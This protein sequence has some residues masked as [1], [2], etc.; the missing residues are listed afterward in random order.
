MILGLSELADSDVD[1]QCWKPPHEQTAQLIQRAIRKYLDDPKE[2]Y[3]PVEAATLKAAAPLLHQHPHLADHIRAHVRLN[4]NRWVSANTQH[5]GHRVSPA[6]GQGNIDFVRDIVSYGWGPAIREI[7]ESGKRATLSVW[8]NLAFE[9]TTDPNELRDYLNAVTQSIFTY[10]DDFATSLNAATEPEWLRI[11]NLADVR[12]IKAVKNL[13]DYTPT[14][15]SRR[16]PDGLDYDVDAP[17]SAVIMWTESHGTTAFEDAAASLA[18][19]SG[20]ARMLVVP[21]SASARWLWLSTEQDIDVEIL[22]NELKHTPGIRVAVGTYGYGLSGFRSSHLDALATQRLMCRLSNHIQVASH[23]ELDV[24]SLVADNEVRARDFV[25]RSLGDL[26][27]AP[28]ELR[29]TLRTYLHE[30]SNITRTAEALYAHR[31]TIVYRLDKIRTLLP[32]PLEG[33]LIKIG[34]ALEI[35]QMI[36]DP[37]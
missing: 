9:L 30:G 34:L 36:G 11:S 23:S 4:I 33:S 31:N 37:R 13:L 12:R 35:S 5:P 8:T 20:A 27:D 14:D 19:V 26:A 25:S 24:I 22:R 21:A 32:T 1:A 16:L 28:H 18:R 6:V 15:D 3:R 7:I 17:H 2:F 29:E 10:C